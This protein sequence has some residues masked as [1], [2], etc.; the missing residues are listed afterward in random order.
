MT[1]K[2]KKRLTEFL[3]ECWHERSCDIYH[4]VQCSCGKEFSREYYCVLEDHIADT[5]RTFTTGNDM[6][7]LKDKLEEK[8]MWIRF[9]RVTRVD[10][11]E[12]PFDEFIAW[13]F[14]PTRFCELVGEFLEKE[15]GI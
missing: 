9:F 4:E 8:R 5:N 13:L 7:D 2:M 10:K 6:A 12:R 3:G 11:R 15:K 1:D 14:T